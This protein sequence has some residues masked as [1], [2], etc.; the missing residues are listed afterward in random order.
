LPAE[1]DAG[2][3]AEEDAA[4]AVDAAAAAEAFPEEVMVAVMAEVAATFLEGAMVAGVT[5]GAEGARLSVLGAVLVAEISLGQ[6][7][8]EIFLD[9]AE[10]DATP[11]PPHIFQ[12][13]RCPDRQRG[14]CPVAV[15]CRRADLNVP[16]ALVHPPAAARPSYRPAIGLLLNPAARPERVPHND[17]PPEPN[18]HVARPGLG[19]RAEK[20]GPN[21]V[22]N[23][24]SFL[25]E[26]TG[27]FSAPL[28]ERAQG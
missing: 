18:H 15:V 12:A 14:R 24:H 6:V 1:E 4:A 21:R 17:L 19:H 22:A 27:I 7:V 13:A 20:Q 10:E 9:Q 25:E 26:V 3:V 5:L 8:A 23:L 28:R 16:P 11:F 2:A